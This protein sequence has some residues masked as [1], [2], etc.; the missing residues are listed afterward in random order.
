[1]A[2]NLVAALKP[3]NI[4]CALVGFFYIRDARVFKRKQ[5]I[6]FKILDLLEAFRCCICLLYII[7]FII[8]YLKIF[9]YN[10]VDIMSLIGGF[11][12]VVDHID[13]NV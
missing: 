11:T 7:Y 1:M 12:V 4:F 6:F 10:K 13:V 2:N 9:K 8:R 5:C 3:I